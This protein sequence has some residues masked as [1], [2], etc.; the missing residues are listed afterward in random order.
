MR[1]SNNLNIILKAIDKAANYILRDF[2][3]LEN[4]QAN[5][6]VTKKFTDACYQKVKKII[7]EDLYKFKPEY[8]IH[9]SD[10]EYLEGK[11]SQYYFTIFAIDGIN[12]L[13][14]ANGD[15]V[16]G[17]ALS[18][19]ETYSQSN[20]IAVAIKKVISNEIFYCEKG[21]GTF[22]NNKRVKISARQKD[23]I[24]LT[25]SLSALG[26]VVSKKFDVSLRNYGSKLLEIAYLSCN[27]IDCL[28]IEANKKQKYQFFFLLAQE[29]GIKIIDNKDS[30]IMINESLL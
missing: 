8:N 11:D 17:I 29:S 14:R 12:N 23:E 1:Y 18:Y 27:R 5:S 28:E 20:S 6:R 9:F 13:A 2:C 19:G 15:F 16:I 26:K 24:I 7:G 3:E 10:G 25:N 30:I 22:F 21:F 4:L